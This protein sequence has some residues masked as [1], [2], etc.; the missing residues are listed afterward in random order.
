MRH[1]HKMQ[2]SGNRS[3]PHLE[4]HPLQKTCAMKYPD[5]SIIC[6]LVTAVLLSGCAHEASPRFHAHSMPLPDLVIQMQSNRDLIDRL[7]NSGGNRDRLDSKLQLLYADQPDAYPSAAIGDGQR[8]SLK[9][10]FTIDEKG[11][12]RNV[13]VIEATH[14]LVAQEYAHYITRWKFAPPRRN[15]AATAV[16]REIGVHLQPRAIDGST[17]QTDAGSGIV[18]QGKSIAQGLLLS[19]VTNAYQPVFR[20]LTGCDRPERIERSFLGYYRPVTFNDAGMAVAGE[21]QERWVAPRLPQS[22][23]RLRLVHLYTTGQDPIHDLDL[24]RAGAHHGCCLTFALISTRAAV[25]RLA[26]RI[27]MPARHMV[28]G[29]PARV[30]LLEAPAALAEHPCVGPR[31]DHLADEKVVDL[32]VVRLRHQPARQPSR[33]S[34]HERQHAMPVDMEELGA[35]VAQLAGVGGQAGVAQLMRQA[36]LGHGWHLDHKAPAALQ[37]GAR[38]RGLIDH[39]GELGG[40]EIERA[41]PGGRHYIGGPV[42]MS[43]DEHGG[44]VVDEASGLGELDGGDVRSHGYH[45]QRWPVTPTRSFPAP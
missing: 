24:A 9:L 40:R 41:G 15:T 25:H 42:V 34:R 23:H 16:S 14:P 31:A 1:K 18:Y 6:L 33:A 5:C 7:V 19:D 44:A 38:G 30:G 13:Q 2:S 32:L 4:R 17:V 10:G 45:D 11:A 20:A 36:R 28:Q 8:A 35:S 29:A 21:A 26:N 27:E 37:Q 22:A 3:M 39:H 43:R 12:T